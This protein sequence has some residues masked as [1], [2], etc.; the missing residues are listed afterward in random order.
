[1]EIDQDNHLVVRM[2]NDNDSTSHY[3]CICNGAKIVDDKMISC[4]IDD[5]YGKQFH[6]SCLNLEGKRV[7]ARWRCDMCVKK[8]KKRKPLATIN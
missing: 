1:M 8:S 7:T 6:R 3:P 5:C 4:A 2:C